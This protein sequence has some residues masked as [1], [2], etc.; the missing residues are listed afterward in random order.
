MSDVRR[1]MFF[2]QFGARNP[3]R[4]VEECFRVSIGEVREQFD[5]PELIQA[6]LDCAPIRIPLS[7]GRS[8]EVWLTCDTHPLVGKQ[9]RW[10]CLEDGTARL[11]FICP[12]CRR[13][14]LARLYYFTDPAGK[15]ASQLLCRRC[16]NLAYLSVNCAGNAFYRHVVR[17]LRRLRRVETLLRSPGA[18]ANQTPYP[19]G[20]RGLSESSSARGR[21]EVRPSNSCPGTC[22]RWRPPSR[23][24]WSAADLQK[25]RVGMSLA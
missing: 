5:R 6:I 9:G 22:G 21:Q 23:P 17:P 25:P 14:R 1:T 18:G 11:W 2:R 3:K 24:L 8:A 19:R 4:L 12:G 15:W 13:H 10:S 20:R 7:L 16:H